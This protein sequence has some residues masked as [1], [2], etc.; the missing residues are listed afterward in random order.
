MHLEIISLQRYNSFERWFLRGTG[1]IVYHGSDHIITQPVFHGG[2]RTN[3]YGYGF[4]MTESADLGREWAC[5]G[6]TDG[7]L[8]SYELD[9]EGLSVLNF[10]DEAYT[11][12]NWLA[13]LTHY[14]TYWEKGSIAE[15]AKNYLQENFFVDVE[16][17]D[18]I[19]GYRADDSYFS[20]A[21]DFVAGTISLRKLSE[22]MRLGKLGEQIVLKS[23]KAHEAASFLQAEPVDS[24]LYYPKRM[25]RDRT[26]RRE[27]RESRNTADNVN[28]IYMLDILREGMTNDDLRLR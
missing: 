25:E 8:N 6:G 19:R 11:I 21:R 7:F 14:R 1:M 12:L 13:V 9:T 27:Y 3:D 22:A 20:F 10:N 17:Y 24:S 28:D 26:A 4:Y 2:K 23:R 18:V 5:S 15:E 16:R